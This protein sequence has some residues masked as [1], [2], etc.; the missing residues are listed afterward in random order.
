V[1]QAAQERKLAV[2]R[3]IVEDYVAFSEPVGSKAVVARYGLGV[4]SATIRS[5]MVA[6]ENAGL[7][8]QPHTSAGR[9]PTDAGYR[10]FVDHL[11]QEKPLAEW[12]KNAIHQFFTGAESHDDVLARASRLVAEL[13][14]Q[15]AIVQYPTLESGTLKHLELVELPAGAFA[16][17]RRLLVVLI[18]NTGKVSQLYV[19]IDTSPQNETNNWLAEFDLPALTQQLNR[20]GNGQALVDLG[21][22]FA[23]LV[24]AAPPVIGALIQRIAA[25]IAAAGEESSEKRLVVSGAASLARRDNEL[26][27]SALTLL[28]ALEEQVTILRL[29]ADMQAETTPQQPQKPQELNPIR[30]RIGAENKAVGLSQVAVVTAEYRPTPATTRDAAVIGTIGPTRIDYPA[31]MAKV[32]GVAHYLTTSLPS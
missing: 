17:G 29:L 2:L 3:A 31:T 21:Q 24:A 19:N 15:I 14:G 20:A 6:L 12:Q 16:E 7:I 22:A 13:T 23:P 27:A 5:D 26:E 25:A 18:S 8:T 1:S 28:E 10:L 32:R 9:V 4:S 11:A 30:V